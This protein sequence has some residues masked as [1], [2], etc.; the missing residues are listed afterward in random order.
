[1]NTTT[2]MSTT[3]GSYIKAY[4][5]LCK[6]RV[7]LLIVITALVGMC[8]AAPH[9]IALSV[10]VFGN[11]GIML[12]ACAAAAVNHVVDQHI[13]EKMHRTR[14]RPLVKGLL[15]PWQ[16]CLFAAV[17]GLIAML[18]LIIAVNVLTATLTF[19]TLIGYAVVYTMFL[20]HATPQNIVIGGLA[21]AA[22]PLL[23]W[24]A[25]TG[26]IDPNALLLVLIVFLWTPPHFWALAI[27]RIE[28]YS[29]AKVPMLPNTHGIAFTKFNIVIYTV[30]LLLATYLPF[31]SGMLGVAYLIGVSVL[32]LMFLYYVCQLLLDTKNSLKLFRFSITYLFA[33]F[34]V[35]LFT[36]YI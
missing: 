35:M 16:A 8:L 5:D 30:L 20:K 7:V 18:I 34:I 4:L 9:G 25:V 23:G 15:Q 28:D 36:H 33:L 17:L 21:G 3:F 12:A 22:P 32:N 11:I 31:F 13:D 14:M 19:I 26:H 2:V 6:L 27:H 29:K 1:M 24:T 10:L